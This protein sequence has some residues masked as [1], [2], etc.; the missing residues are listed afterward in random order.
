MF[1]CLGLACLLLAIWTT[2][3]SA[4]AELL[5]GKRERGWRW[6]WRWRWSVV[7]PLL[8]AGHILDGTGPHILARVV[9]MAN[10][11]SP[12]L[13]WCLP[14]AADNRH[15]GRP[16][17]FWRRCKRAKQVVRGE[18]VVERWMDHGVVNG[19]PRLRLPG[20][21]RLTDETQFSGRQCQQR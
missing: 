8:A 2:Y 12:C 11:K 4:T 5:M 17:R 20:V 18:A 6:R 14:R 10:A 21:R 15:V 7:A 19:R 13:S 9:Q 3:L 1:A 16:Q